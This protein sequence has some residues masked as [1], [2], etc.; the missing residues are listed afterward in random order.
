MFGVGCPS[1]K[2]SKEMFLSAPAI[3]F[4]IFSFRVTVGGAEK[5]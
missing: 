4:F 2:H 5:G 3:T 1:T